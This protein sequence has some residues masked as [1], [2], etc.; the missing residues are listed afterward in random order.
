MQAIRAAKGGPKDIVANLPKVNSHW[1]LPPGADF[2][3]VQKHETGND[4]HVNLSPPKYP[5]HPF[6]PELCAQLTSYPSGL[7]DLVLT[8]KFSYDFIEICT[9]TVKLHNILDRLRQQCAAGLP[10]PHAPSSQ[11]ST[12][13]SPYIAASRVS[14]EEM[15]LILVYQPLIEFEQGSAL[16]QKLSLQRSKRENI[17]T[18]TLEE[19]LTLGLIAFQNYFWNRCRYGPL[20][21]ILRCDLA[22]TLSSCHHQIVMTGTV[23]EK[24]ALIWLLMISTVAFDSRL[25][26]LDRGLKV[27]REVRTSFMEIRRHKDRHRRRTSHSWPSAS[28]AD[29]ASG[30]SPPQKKDSNSGTSR[31]DEIPQF[32]DWQAV[33]K[34]LKRFFLPEENMN[35]WGR[36]WRAC[37]QRTNVD[38]VEVRGTTAG[39]LQTMSQLHHADDNS[40]DEYAHEKQD[41][42]NNKGDTSEGTSK[43][44]MWFYNSR[45]GT[46][47]YL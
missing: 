30:R 14:P 6:S 23:A 44:R 28:S 15:G 47:S 32:E 40:P 12:P 20:Y 18:R 16:L 22:D 1:Y 24:Q 42:H 17:N 34:C 27:F 35:S 7:S 38:V 45:K 37:V 8:E 10:P 5:K 29:D 41:R 39:Q 31:Q 21:E 46:D 33:E 4:D 9:R 43:A 2:F 25:G 19:A 11:P 26:T 36:M 13:G 3:T